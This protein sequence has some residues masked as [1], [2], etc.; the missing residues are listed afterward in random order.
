MYL[1]NKEKKSYK[2][3]LISMLLLALCFMIGGTVFA[4]AEKQK[5]LCP[6]NKLIMVRQAFLGEMISKYCVYDCY[7]NYIGS[8]MNWDYLQK[9]VE[10]KDDNTIGVIYGKDA[11]YIYLL[12]EHMKCLTLDPF[13]GN[14]NALDDLLVVTEYRENGYEMMKILNRE[15]K[16]LFSL[17]QKEFNGSFIVTSFK[18]VKYIDHEKEATYYMALDTD[19]EGFQEM[20]MIDRE[21]NLLD[22]F[23]KPD[24]ISQALSGDIGYRN[25]KW[26]FRGWE[27]TQ[28]FD[29][30]GN[31]IESCSNDEFDEIFGYEGYKEDYTYYYPN[32]DEEVIVDQNK[33]AVLI[34]G[35]KDNEVY[36]RIESAKTG[37]VIAEGTGTGETFELK[38]KYYIYNNNEY[39]EDYSKQTIYSKVCDY[40]GNVLLEFNNAKV[41]GWKKQE[42]LTMEHGRYR[43]LIDLDGNWVL[44]VICSDGTD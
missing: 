26:Y 22:T 41:G 38:D 15:G 29:A 23:E 8:T 11:T 31:Q 32:D 27:D 12:K 40:K 28:I 18:K 17:P 7:G 37:K 36:S 2:S 35:R 42:Y 21:G 14:V 5:R 34:K 6:K 10:I 44:K 19:W 13:N 25:G 33:K 30:F 16:E 9:N 24:F 3:I 1:H 39:N 4:E 43:G 20:Y